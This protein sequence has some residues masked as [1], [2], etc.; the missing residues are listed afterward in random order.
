M[1]LTLGANSI[2][3]LYLGSTAINKAYL[4]AT[5]LFSGGGAVPFS[6][7]SLFAGGQQG[8]WLEVVQSGEFSPASLF[9]GG[10]AG[11]WY[12]PSD[13]TTLFQDSAGTTPVTAS[14]QP[15]GKML[16]KSGNGNHATQATSSKRPTYMSG[17][18]LHWLA[19]DGAD[20]VLDVP[21]IAQGV[22]DYAMAYAPAARDFLVS[23]RTGSPGGW[24]GVGLDGSPSTDL[25]DNSGTQV[26]IRFNNVVSTATTRG[27]QYTLAQNA[28]RVTVNYNLTGTN[29]GTGLAIGQYG[30][31][32]T[33]PGSVYGYFLR[34]GT[35]TVAQHTFLDDYFRGKI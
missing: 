27:G 10:I 6:P 16:D 13:L 1:A 2:N 22:W 15:V 34:Q 26:S 35:L 9:A 12:D 21:L 28:S 30:S 24:V 8:L 14:G 33:T 29:T 11:A 5:V 7:A 20:D 19:F 3:K 31:G 32:L 23:H 4:G 18:G 17:S 25:D